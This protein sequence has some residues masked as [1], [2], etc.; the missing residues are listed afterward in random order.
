ML[1]YILF[2]SIVVL[3]IFFS[4]FPLSLAFIGAVVIYGIKIIQINRTKFACASLS[5]AEVRLTPH[6][7]SLSDLLL[8]TDIRLLLT[9]LERLLRMLVFQR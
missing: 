3:N 8:P 1:S 2:T 7:Q 6:A 4:A 9:M 5:R